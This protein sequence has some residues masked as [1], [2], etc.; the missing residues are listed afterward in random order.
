[1][2]KV[3]LFLTIVSLSVAAFGR[4]KDDEHAAEKA[5]LR[6]DIA[7][8][9]A[10]ITALNKKILQNT[11]E[12]RTEEKQH[13]VYTKSFAEELARD[14]K[15]LA[16][17]EGEFKGLQKS[18]DSLARLIAGVQYK[19]V[20]FSRKQKSFTAQL[21]AALER[22]AVAL[23]AVPAPIVAKERSS[24]A[25]L[26]KEIKAGAVGNAEGLERLWQLSK[27]VAGNRNSID[28]WSGRSSCGAIEGQVHYLR[29]GYGWLACVNDD[30]TKAA[31]WNGDEATDGW[32][33]L[34]DPAHCNAI[35]AA[36]KVRNGN[37][38]PEILSLPV[39]Y[40]AEATDEQ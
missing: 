31:L 2:H 34:S 27:S 32:L 3:T 4:G 9:E 36:V 10:D 23:A 39:H 1:M 20:E 29:I 40:L 30:G 25:F 15:A 19:G 13:E 11:K 38:L 17:L 5:A 6:T 12:R 33:N 14:S 7:K 8:Y 37:R 16:S 26:T 35:R 28:V 22:Y 21:L 18:A 24:L